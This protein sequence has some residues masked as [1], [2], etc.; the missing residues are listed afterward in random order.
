MPKD[1]NTTKK[2][3]GK[4]RKGAEG[5]ASSSLDLFSIS[6]TKEDLCSD[7]S[8]SSSPHCTYGAP[9]FGY[10]II[11]KTWG[12][13]QGCCNHWDCPKC[14]IKRAKQEYG[15]IVE[16]ARHLAKENDLYFI[17][18]TCR[19]KE[20]TLHEA[21]THYLE[22]TNRFLDAARLK[23]KR[24]NQSWAYVQVTERQRR[25]HPHSHILTTFNPKDIKPGH[26]AKYTT[27]N[28]GKKQ[29]HLVERLRSAWIQ[30]Q[31]VRSGLGSEY[32]ISRVQT[33]EGCSRYVA[34][35]MFKDTMFGTHWPK[36]WHRVRYSQS[37]PKLAE[38]STNAVPLLSREDWANLAKLALV[39]RVEDNSDLA[40]V[41]WSLRGHDVIIR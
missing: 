1:N 12:V 28:Q 3:P 33:V 37:W 39:V 9:Y 41:Y 20:L 32:D 22:W 8:S 26:T 38:R 29:K 24:D 25:G 36:S 30:K 21:Q 2:H 19:G 13:V 23:A 31:V 18:L 5:A 34:K 40:G 16:G 14:G 27:D 6:P 7:F 4:S 11:G 10:Q 15:R 17:T 35:Y